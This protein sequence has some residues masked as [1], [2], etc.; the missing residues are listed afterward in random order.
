VNDGIAIS[1]MTYAE[2][3]EGIQFGSD[4]AIYETG[5]RRLVAGLRVLGINR[6]VARRYAAIR[7]DLH[8]R[9]LLIPQPDILIAATAIHYNLVPVTRDKLERIA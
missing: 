4:R 1:I 9:G 8:G 5:L 7:G 2:V 6:T 3:Y